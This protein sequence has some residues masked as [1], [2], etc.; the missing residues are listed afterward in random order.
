MTT[1]KLV[2]VLMLTATMMLPTGCGGVN[3]ALTS[4]KQTV[5][6][7]RIYNLATDAG[8]QAVGKAASDGLGRNTSNINTTMPIPASAELP[9]KPG[10]FKITDPMAGTKLGAL[11]SMSGGLGFKTAECEGAAWTAKAVRTVSGSNTL[12]LSTCLFQYKG[13]YHLDMYATF[14]KVEGGLSEISRQMAY[15]AVGTPEEWVEKTFN[16]VLLKIR[17]Q[18]GAEITY[19]EGYPEPGPLP[20][21]DQGDRAGQPASPKPGT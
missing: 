19:L 15:A 21:L 5:E 10:R 11:A 18:T 6:Y 17:E 4:K 9:E 16:D 20:W 13:G 8:K 1:D 2:A 12:N 7:Y 14:T 3:N